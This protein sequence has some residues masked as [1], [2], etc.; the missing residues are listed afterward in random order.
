MQSR[1][2]SKSNTATI[3]VASFAV[4]SFAS[5]F[6]VK[7]LDIA[8]FELKNNVTQS[9]SSSL[10]ISQIEKLELIEAVNLPLTKS[11]G[12]FAGIVNSTPS[13]VVNSSLPYDTL[14]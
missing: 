6:S 4:I 5:P 13:A 14:S 7:S 2:F 1:I 12:S 10:A 11:P 9:T 8:T 3:A